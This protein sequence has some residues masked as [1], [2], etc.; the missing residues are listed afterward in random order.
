MGL[1]TLLEA[2]DV[3]VL[4]VAAVL[5]Q[6]GDDRVC[7]GLLADEREFDRVGLHA[8]PGLA[9]RRH[10]VDV[11]AQPDRGHDSSFFTTSETRLASRL[12]RTSDGPSTM[13][14]QTGSVPEYRTRIRPS[15]PIS[16]S[17][18]TIASRS[19]GTS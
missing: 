1:E 10:V 2:G 17:A 11:H 3:V 13:T 18:A 8:P 4:D 5:A 6:V 19:A 14:R 9:D 16:F 15:S 12:T 7:A